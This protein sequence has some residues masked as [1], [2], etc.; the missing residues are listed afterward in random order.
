MAELKKIHILHTNDIHSHVEQM[1]KLASVIRQ[2]RK[3]HQPENTLVVDIG[4]HMDRMQWETEGTNGFFNLAV[5]NETGYDAVCIGNNEGLTYPMSVLANTFKQAKFETIAANMLDESTGTIPSWILP[6]SIF[7][8][9]GLHIGLIGLTVPYQAFYRLLGWNVTDPVETLQLWLPTLRPKVDVLILLSHLGLSKDKELAEQF[10]ELDLI[11]GGHTHHL[12][13]EPIRV[14][15]TVIGG[16]GKFGD[17]VGEIEIEWNTSYHEIA[18]ISGHVIPVEG[19]APADDIVKLLEKYRAESNVTLS[20]SVAY[21]KRPLPVNWKHE[22][23][24]GNLL[25]E[26]L[27]DWVDAEIGI[28]NAGQLLNGLKAGPVTKGQLLKLCPSPINPCRL[29]LSG[30]DIWLTMEESLLDEYQNKEIRGFG[31]R[32]KVLGMLCLAGMKVEYDGV[33][34]AYQK[35][36]SIHINDRPLDRKKLYKIGTIDMF[37]FG[38]GYGRFKQATEIEFSLPEFLRDVLEKELNREHAIEH[39]FDFRW[40]KIRP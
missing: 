40:L 24:L 32:G 11:L 39:S 38:V 37:T 2:R 6:Y 5:L 20:Q 12:L 28:V 8:R 30:E 33:R 36:K 1:G 18:N 16:A 10:S 23:P 7:Q 31:F 27:R 29:A 15:N 13:Q 22:S 3:I 25:A 26:G 17:Y 9:N 35:I 19:V 4:D 21:L 34:P 14:G